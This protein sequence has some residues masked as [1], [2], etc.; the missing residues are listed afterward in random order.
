[1]NGA[2]GRDAARERERAHE[3]A[4]VESGGFDAEMENAE[5]R[6]EG[7]VSELTMGVMESIDG[8]LV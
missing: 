3:N 5:K 6:T 1:M 4:A 8:S 7:T 2:V